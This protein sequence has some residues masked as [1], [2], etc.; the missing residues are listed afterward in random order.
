MTVR[1][2]G[3]A[4]TPEDL[5]GAT[6][7]FYG[8]AVMELYRTINAL[9]AEEFTE[10]SAAQT[11]IRDL[12]AAALAG[13]GGKGQRLTN[14]ANTIAGHDR[15]RRGNR[16]STP[17]ELKSGAAWLASATPEEVDEFL[18][19]SWGRTRC[20]RCRGSSNSGHCR[21]SC[22]RVGPGR[23]G[24]SWAGA[25]R[26]R[27]GPGLGMGAG[28]SGRRGPEDP[29]AACGGWR[30]WARRWIRWSAM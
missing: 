29:G 18:S 12:R 22:R 1:F 20:W 4:P 10:V 16:P 9:R 19:G 14:F 23:P 3:D 6:E 24:S 11:A 26:A 25:G 5:L 27:R 13:A 21:T 2:T 17:P 8:L 15:P 30:W 7:S 28:A